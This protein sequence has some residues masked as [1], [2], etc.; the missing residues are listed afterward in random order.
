M[1]LSPHSGPIDLKILANLLST[2]LVELGYSS[3][4]LFGAAGPSAAV[5]DAV[6]HVR[7]VIEK[8]CDVNEARRA[9][10]WLLNLPDDHLLDVTVELGMEIPTPDASERRRF[11]ELLWRETFAEWKVQGFDPN[12]YEIVRPE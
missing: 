7:R 9:L 1:L 5:I 6:E 11:L 10:A 2:Q 8:D 3:P 12:A 4:P